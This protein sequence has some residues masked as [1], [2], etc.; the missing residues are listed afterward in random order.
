MEC[1]LSYNTRRIVTRVQ[2]LKSTDQQLDDDE[3]VFANFQDACPALGI[4]HGPEGPHIE[5]ILF[6][7]LMRHCVNDHPN[8]RHLM[9][10]Y[11]RVTMELV[12]ALIAMNLPED[13]VRRDFMLWTYLVAVD[14]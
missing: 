10:N 5:R 13:G 11:L 1:P 9:I 14:S 6:L 7:A 2:H 12:R 8:H 4:P 3:P